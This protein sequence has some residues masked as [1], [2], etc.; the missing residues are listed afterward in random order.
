[1][2]PYKK[3]V[4]ARD[5]SSILSS[6]HKL[7]IVSRSSRMTEPISKS[8]PVHDKSRAKHWNF[9]PF[10]NTTSTHTYDIVSNSNTIYSTAF[11]KFPSQVQLACSGFG[12]P[13]KLHSF[14]SEATFDHILLF[15]FRSGF[16]CTSS[17]DSIFNVHP[18]YNHLYKSLLRALKV[19]FRPICEPNISW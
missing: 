17:L 15:L 12:R 2:V 3:Q 10:P 18:L 1:M 7:S 8:L 4:P 9:S 16:L 13:S 14:T 19:D 11:G 6:P 5:I